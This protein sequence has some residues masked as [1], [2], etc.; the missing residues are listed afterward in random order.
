MQPGNVFSWEDQSFKNLTSVPPSFAT[1]PLLGAVQIRIRAISAVVVFKKIHPALPCL[2]RWQL[3][4]SYFILQFHLEGTDLIKRVIEGKLVRTEITTIPPWLSLMKANDELLSSDSRNRRR[5]AFISPLSDFSPRGEGCCEG[6]RASYAKQLHALLTI[7]GWTPPIHTPIYEAYH[8][9]EFTTDKERF[10]ECTCH[11]GTFAHLLTYH[12]F[13][14]LAKLQIQKSLSASLLALQAAHA[15]R[16][17]LYAV[18]H[19]VL[20]TNRFGHTK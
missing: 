5:N 18:Q 19:G 16:H 10:L 3:R 1:L 8:R 2:R 12:H 6:V 20:A 4:S 13:P 17:H 15:R 9:D 14:P 7:G 11:I